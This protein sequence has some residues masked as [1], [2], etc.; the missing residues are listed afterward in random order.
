MRSA[1]E[2]FYALPEI[3]ALL[4]EELAPLPLHAARQP[5]GRALLLQPDAAA[6]ALPV[7]VGAPER[8]A[9]ARERRCAR[10]AT[11]FVRP[12]RLPI[13]DESF[14]L[15]FAQHLGDAQ[16]DDGLVEELARVIAPG[17]LLL[18]CGFN[19]WSPWLA[20]IHWH[21]R[22]GGAV[23]QIS[24]ADALRR[25]LL[26]SKLAPVA[27]DYLGT[28]WPRRCGEC[29]RGGRP[30]RTPAGAPARRVPAGRAQAARRADAAAPARQAHRRRA[31]R[32]SRRH[33]EPARLRMT[34][35]RTAET[36][37]VF[38]D[39][40][41][42]GNPGPGGWAAL[43]RFGTREKELSGGEPETTNNRMELM[44]AIAGI[45]AL[46]RAC[47]VVVTTDSEYV[48]RGVEEWLKRWQA[49]GW[50]TSDKKPVKNRDLWERLSAALASHQVTLA[51]GA[52]TFRPRRER[53]RRRACARSG[54]EVQ[55]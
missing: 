25:R 44:A 53:A 33:A 30:S 48:R 4:R 15:V 7:D 24:N 47:T 17:G 3:E 37:E 46:K 42:L 2:S 34:A 54:V 45:E 28:C 1:T 14:Q 55:G 41:C 11:S 39:G 29:E 13:E 51:L 10:A 38:T 20:W 31:R 18:W 23:P 26:R 40:A 52:R 19:P 35:A 16:P 43:L 32:A 5:G 9:P 27:L 21:T 6:R 49:N 36:V 12:A 22:G 50:R 8:H